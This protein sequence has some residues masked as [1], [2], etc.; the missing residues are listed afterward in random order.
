MTNRQKKAMKYTFKNCKH[1]QRE[2]HKMRWQQ[3]FKKQ[4]ELKIGIGKLKFKMK[5]FHLAVD[6]H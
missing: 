3:I 1:E 6:Y 4:L 2:Q 5:A